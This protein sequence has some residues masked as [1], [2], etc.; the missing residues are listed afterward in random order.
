MLTRRGPQGVRTLG[1]RRSASGASAR[2]L[3]LPN[4]QKLIGFG[5]IA[6]LI[7][8]SFMTR[9]LTHFLFQVSATDGAAF[10]GGALLLSAVALLACYIPARR[11]SRLDPLVAL[12]YE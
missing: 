12:R 2:W 4:E 8:A 5:V 3:G 6:G 1:R 9:V 11:A 7:A 10:A